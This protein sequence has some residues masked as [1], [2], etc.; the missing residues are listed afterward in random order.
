M[1][2]QKEYRRNATNL[3]TIISKSLKCKGNKSRSSR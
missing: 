1:N 3:I 2:V